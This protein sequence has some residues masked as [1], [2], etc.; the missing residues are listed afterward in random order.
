MRSKTGGSRSL[1]PVADYLVVGGGA[2]RGFVESSVVLIVLEDKIKSVEGLVA[3][4]T[5]QTSRPAPGTVISILRNDTPFSR[6][7]TMH[8]S[9]DDTIGEVEI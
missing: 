9:V 7:S 4:E 2:Y 3:N 8:G 5:G 6:S 1:S